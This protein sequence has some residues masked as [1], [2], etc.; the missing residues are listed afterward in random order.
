MRRRYIEGWEDVS[1]GL[2]SVNND[3]HQTLFGHYST[4]KLRP[5]VWR[6]H[7]YPGSSDTI[8]LRYTVDRVSPSGH[9]LEEWSPPNPT[10][11]PRHMMWSTVLWL[12]DPWTLYTFIFGTPVTLIYRY[13]FLTT[14]GSFSILFRRSLTTRWLFDPNFL[15]PEETVEYYPERRR[16]RFV[17]LSTSGQGSGPEFP[18]SRSLPIWSWLCP[19]NM[20]AVQDK[21]L[22]TRGENPTSVEPFSGDYKVHGSED[23]RTLEVF[24]EWWKRI[25]LNRV[26]GKISF[27][28]PERVCTTVHGGVLDGDGREDW[29]DGY[30]TPNSTS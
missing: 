12:Y 30:I 15:S 7:R 23:L 1:I 24:T 18:G 19:D 21:P 26:T 6:D 3:P 27:T 5:S 17:S 22:F 10:T 4:P 2:D 9:Q 20:I 8:L 13:R 14:T 16:R 25:L 28:S 11:W 29:W